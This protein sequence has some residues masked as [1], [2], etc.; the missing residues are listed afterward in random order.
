MEIIFGDQNNLN[1]VVI[2]V[3][4]A[5]MLPLMGVAPRSISVALKDTAANWQLNEDFQYWSNVFFTEV[6]ISDDTNS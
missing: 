6:V 1:L 4:Q 5:L 3:S 2:N